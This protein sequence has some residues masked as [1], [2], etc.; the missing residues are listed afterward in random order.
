[1]ELFLDANEDYKNA[2]RKLR[3]SV[4]AD[5]IAECLERCLITHRND[6]V[7]KT[8]LKN[9]ANIK[10]GWENN[11]LITRSK[12]PTG[13]LYRRQFKKDAHDITRENVI[14]SNVKKSGNIKTH[15]FGN[16]KRWFKTHKK[17]SI[18]TGSAV[19]LAG[20]GYAGYK[21]GWLSP[22]FAT[23]EECGKKPGYLSVVG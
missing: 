14:G 6:D 19:V 9:Q 7:A 23:E 12:E 8:I 16:L 15:G 1:M 13:E 2:L 20:L 3:D 11:Q 5:D 21:T 4:M 18:I 17:A 22:K 10:T